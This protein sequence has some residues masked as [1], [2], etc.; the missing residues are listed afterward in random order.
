MND[1]LNLK[2]AEIKYVISRLKYD[3]P[4]KPLDPCNNYK[5]IDNYNWDLHNK[6]HFDIHIEKL[7]NHYNK[8]NKCDS[9]VWYNYNKG[10]I[11]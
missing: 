3:L 8:C 7:W 1:P 4:P 5:M 2:N 9:G 11:K 6:K 10:L